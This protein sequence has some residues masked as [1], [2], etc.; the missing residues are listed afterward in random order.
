MDLIVRVPQQGHSKHIAGR[1]S[2]LQCCAQMHLSQEHSVCKM[3]EYNDRV[4]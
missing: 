3:F 4:N 1:N 2:D